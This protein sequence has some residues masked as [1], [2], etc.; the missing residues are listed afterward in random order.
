MSEEAPSYERELS[1][2]AKADIAQVDRA[3][4]LKKQKIMGD[5]L[6]GKNDGEMVPNK[7]EVTSSEYFAN[8]PAEGIIRND[9]ALQNSMT[10]RF[11]STDNYLAQTEITYKN[12]LDALGSV[13]TGVELSE[14]PNYENMNMKT[15]AI[16]L[17]KA[18]MLGD[19]AEA[20]TIRDTFEHLL[21][22]AATDPKNPDGNLTDKQYN[23]EI[24]RF[25]HLVELAEGQQKSKAQERTAT[26]GDVATPG[27]EADTG[28]EVNAGTDKAAEAGTDPSEAGDER[29]V[30][31]DGKDVFVQRKFSDPDG[32]EIFE[33][34]M[35]D[36]TLRLFREEELTFKDL[37]AEEEG[38]LT[39]EKNTEATA[40]AAQEK[41]VA[42][43]KNKGWW[44]KAVGFIKQKF[45]PSYIGAM[46]TM[47]YKDIVD[48]TINR[49]ID[50]T[51]NPDDYD[52]IR[53]K[54][55]IIFVLGAAAVVAG[56]YVLGHEISN[57]VDAN[58]VPAGGLNGNT[59]PGNG[60]LQPHNGTGDA[61][62]IPQ[63]HN[64]LE[65][66]VPNNAAP[67]PEVT[68]PDPAYDVSNGEGG[69]ELFSTAHI[70]PAKWAANIDRLRAMYPTS[71]YDIDIKNGGGVGLQSQGWLPQGLREQLD[72]LK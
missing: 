70:N 64:I 47:T 7:D 3:A 50:M 57:L 62:R 60:D 18:N 41:R 53:N 10:G 39:G 69:L 61:F 72:L 24:A 43:E 65:Q 13:N 26:S 48:H 14:S 28:T 25:D 22:E 15:L 11:E 44:A 29:A 30:Y 5:E 1:D 2:A 40:D 12:R 32:V 45:S 17:S 27:A 49:G 36:G 6:F 35:P 19:I 56:A 46:W 59:L 37:D 68:A 63:Q 31:F 67:G 21:M 38:D 34:L 51:T 4:E 66:P 20:K 71:F 8:R 23:E 42:D 16:L 55:R 54:N 58:N 33:V 9:N 52:R